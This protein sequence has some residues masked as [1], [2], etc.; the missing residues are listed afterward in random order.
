VRKIDEPPPLIHMTAQK[1]F[2]RSS[3]MTQKTRIY[4]YDSTLRDGSQARGVDFSV[5]DKIALSKK[6]DDFGIDYIEGGW[7]GANPN[8]DQ[9]FEKSPE[10][11]HSTLTAFGMTRKANCSAAND[12]GLSAVLN[13]HLGSVCLV[14]KSWDFQVETALQ[15][16]LEE[17][18]A[19]IRESISHVVS[20]KREALFDAE[21]FFDGYKHNPEYALNALKSAA[22]AGADWLVLCDTNGGTLPHEIG[23][24]VHAASKALPDAKFGVH[25]HNDTEN[26]VANSLAAVQAGVTQIQG[27]LNGV[28]ERCG[29][30]NLI[31][32][33]P[34]LMLKMGYETGVSAEKLPQITALSRFLDERLNRASNPHAAYVGEA[35]FAHKGGLHVSAMARDSRT[36]EHIAPEEVGNERVIL[37]SDKAGRSNV[38]SRLKQMGLTQEAEHPQL[39]ELIAEVKQREM[40]GYAYDAADASFYLLARR[41]LGTVPHY[42]NVEGF[43]AS[44]ERRH[45]MKGELVN[46]SEATMKLTISG[47]M[48]MTASE[49]NGPVNALDG[50]L[51]KALAEHYPQASEV[52][53]TDY[54][55]RILTPQDATKAVTR[56]M[57]ESHNDKG[58][59][60]STIGV[61]ANVIDAS[62]KALYDS[63]IYSLVKEGVEPL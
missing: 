15:V 4:L 32:I 13:G 55:V 22:D 3:S 39:S 28:G 56:V 46:M 1:N 24:I 21:H 14:G 62:F 36:Y 58:E 25:C 33:I 52:K 38:V 63:I 2:A 31:S 23:E 54:K 16:S 60:W 42:F 57:I 45:N 61:S 53:L 29:N 34:S 51:R 10:L 7:P 30:A 47:E 49:G 11:A 6:M 35:A 37:V 41:M 5:S 43:R 12:P 19:M 20:Q 48:V 59:S 17:N 44:D 18:L 8:D 40:Q 50:A 27:T 26:A 9:F